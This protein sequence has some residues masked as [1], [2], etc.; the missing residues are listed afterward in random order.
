MNWDV[1]KKLVDKINTLKLTLKDKSFSTA[2]LYI[3]IR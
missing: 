1:F 3:M 2:N